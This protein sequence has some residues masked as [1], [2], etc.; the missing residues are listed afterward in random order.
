MQLLISGNKGAPPNTR[1][2]GICKASDAWYNAE[3]ALWSGARERE[4]ERARASVGL[5]ELYPRHELNFAAE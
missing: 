5:D 4:S 3:Q 1:T 2:A